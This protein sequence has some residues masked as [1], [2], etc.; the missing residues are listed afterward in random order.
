MVQEY[1]L[2]SVE[3]SNRFFDGKHN[4]QCF[5]RI[6]GKWTNIEE[7]IPQ[8]KPRPY[9]PKSHNYVYVDTPLYVSIS[10]YR[11]WRCAR[12]LYYLYTKAKYP[13]R[14]FAGIVQQNE[15]GD[16]DCVL[17]YCKMM[18]NSFP[19]GHLHYSSHSYT[20]EESRLDNP[21]L[22]IFDFHVKFRGF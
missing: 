6:K 12:T 11:D 4:P 9:P 15:E 13:E 17:E 14:V 10:A 3:A 18:A 16:E 21:D 2:S 22:D 8:G 5:S 20:N 19:E 7:H 1:L